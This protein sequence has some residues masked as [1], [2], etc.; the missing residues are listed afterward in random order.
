MSSDLQPGSSYL[1]D[2][3][4]PENQQSTFGMPGGP[5]TFSHG[6]NSAYNVIPS[7]PRHDLNLDLS[8]IGDHTSPSLHSAGTD[9][10]IC[11]SD[12]E[13]FV[14]ST[15]A[16]SPHEIQV[17][18][19]IQQPVSPAVREAARKRRKNKSAVLHSC[20][21]CGATFTASHNLRCSC[22]S[23]DLVYLPADIE[24]VD[25]FDSK[26][27]GLLRYP[28]KHLGCTYRA[29]APRTATRHSETCKFNPFPTPPKT[30]KR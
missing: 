23:T 6:F 15:F 25:H 24:H 7:Q 27:E 29:A 30:V 21:R 16:Q 3:D 13:P 18:S 5:E 12:V 20:A 1:L 17:S 9:T 11:P 26:H 4:H 10:T 2:P 8:K 14:H 19:T 22:L 28:C